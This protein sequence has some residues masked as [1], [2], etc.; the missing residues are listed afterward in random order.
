MILRI[1]WMSTTNENY[2]IKFVPHMISI[3]SS[4]LASSHGPKP[5]LFPLSWF[6]SFSLPRTVASLSAKFDAF[7]VAILAPCENI[8]K[9]INQR[10]FIQ[11]THNS[12]KTKSNSMVINDIGMIVCQNK[13]NF[14][15][16]RHL[17][18]MFLYVGM[19]KTS[20]TAGK[21]TCDRFNGYDIYVFFL[22]PFFFPFELLLGH[23]K[24][25]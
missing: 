3:R 6:Q 2:A 9:S 10:V 23:L 15:S 21:L 11:N 5:S 20:M 12:S 22:L 1:S 18:H 24:Q 13:Q 14:W 16:I 19:T 7:H 8:Y 25:L 17:F 4:T